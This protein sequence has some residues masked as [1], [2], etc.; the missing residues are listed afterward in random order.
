MVPPCYSNAGMRHGNEVKMK[1]IESLREGERINEIYLCK[2]KQ[3]AMTKAGKP[4]DNLTLQD[5]TGLL[6]AKIW[7]PGSVGIDE[8]DTLDYIAVMGDITSFQG[9]LQL[10]VKRVRKVSEGE[11]EPGDYLP[12]SKR[13]ID[14]MY[15]ELTALIQSVGQPHLKKLLST[16]FLE[17]K[18]F[19][20]RFKFHSAAKT[21]HHGFVGGLLEHTLNVAKHCD[22]FAK[23]YPMLNRDLMVSAA[24]FHD[25]GKLE[26]LSVFPEND[27]TDAGQLL[28]HIMIGAEMVG[29]RIR[30]IQGFPNGVANELKHC[31]LAHHGELEYGSPKKPALAEALALSFADNIDAKMETI[32]EIFAG[33]PEGNVEW[34]GYNRLLESNIRRSGRP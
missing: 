5:K 27:Y 12:V 18:E 11:Y 33:V 6:D 3:S 19:E 24:M 30:S 28:G 7:E 22:Y 14:E 26:E 1:Y 23:M 10:N 15:A 20:K 2:V 31:I 13:N 8:F 34:Q 32:C 29:E 25:I 21:V 9:N 16:F 17:D 4:Y